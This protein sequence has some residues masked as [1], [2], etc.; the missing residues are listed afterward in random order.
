[1][2][3]D[4]KTFTLELAEPFGPVLDALGKR[5][6]NVPL[7]MPARIA[8]TPADEQIKEIVGSGPFRFVR[9]EWQPAIQ[10][11]YVRNAEY[12]PRAEPP[13][14]SAGGKKVY[15]DKVIWRYL[16]D[17]ALV[18]AG[19]A[20]GDV[21][22]W[23]V[24]HIDFIPK[25]KQNPALQTFVI[26]TL[27]AQGWLRPNHVHPPFNNKTARQALLHIMDQTAYLHLAIEQREYYR[28]RHSVFACR[29]P[30]AT[31]APRRS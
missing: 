24:P 1:V 3:T 26:D 9:D 10:A 15:L 12:V 16:P 23:A 5:G 27:G 13:S 8:A 25:I 17:P 4:R 11:V 18:T 31:A 21:D 14:G 7:M 22:W 28:P 29:G 20:D 2:P 6:S 19:L 30:Y